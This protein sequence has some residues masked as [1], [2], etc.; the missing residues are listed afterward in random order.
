MPHSPAD[1]FDAP[2][3]ACPLCAGQ[4]LQDYDQTYQGYQISRCQSC[5]A[6]FMNPQCTDGYLTEFYANY[7][8]DLAPNDLARQQRRRKAKEAIMQLISA[9]ASPG[10]FLSVG[11]GDGLELE[12]AR[13]AGWEVE[14]YDVD[15]T[16]VNRVAKQIDAEIHTGSFC[17]L[18][19]PEGQYDCVYMDQ[20]L[21][22]LKDP[23]S[24][25][26]KAQGLLTP[27][28]LLYIGVPNIMSISNYWKTVSGRIGLQRRRGRHYDLCKHL[29]YFSPSVL[30][31]LMAGRFEF[32]V[33][34]NE[35]TPLSGM[36]TTSESA[37]GRLTADLC[38]RFPFL[39]SSFHLLARKKGQAAANVKQHAQAA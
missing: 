22:H 37:W 2:L 32:D 18:P 19:L 39:D 10:R 5:G 24:Y 28:G 8:C 9:H 17:D 7:N 4:H 33:L 14:G 30:G 16:A 23:V 12:V 38:R 35:G 1:A 29:F 27:G 34:V 15:P 3:T 31:R 25:V 20:V 26:E 21:E 11:C 13:A 6:K 36:K